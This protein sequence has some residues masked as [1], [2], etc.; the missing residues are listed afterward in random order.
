MLNNIHFELVVV[1]QPKATHGKSTAKR[2]ITCLF[3]FS[4]NSR[5]KKN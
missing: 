2:I 1:E 3:L 5:Q 4:I